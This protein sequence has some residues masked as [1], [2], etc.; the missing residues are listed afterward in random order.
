VLIL[1]NTA[2]EAIKNGKSLLPKMLFFQLL[3]NVFFQDTQILI[4]VIASS[5]STVGRST[6]L[7]LLILLLLAGVSTIVAA[8]KPGR[9]SWCT[10]I[11]WGF[12]KLRQPTGERLT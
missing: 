12:S 7:V 2:L 3:F 9:G 1:I 10:P 11:L 6:I 4:V 8:R 5:S